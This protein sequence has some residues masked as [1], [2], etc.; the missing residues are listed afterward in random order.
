MPR[1]K[2]PRW[3]EKEPPATVFKPAGVP[4][5]RLERSVLALDEYEA[6]RL[7]DYEGMKQEDVA[8][9]LGVSRP[10]VSRILDSARRAVAEALA[11]G[12]ALV[13]EG[14]PVELGAPEAPG[15]GAGRRRRRRR[16]RGGPAQEA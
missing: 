1:R 10:T 11:K 2:R 15:R 8:E 7:A 4:A 14:G 6:L 9:R 3:V 16:G 13:I 12:N 5:N